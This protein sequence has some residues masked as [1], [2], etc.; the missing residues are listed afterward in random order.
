ME[1]SG[2]AKT[3]LERR[4]LCKDSQGNLVED[5]PGM[6]MRVA[7]AIAAADSEFDPKADIA[8]TAD[9]FLRLMTELKFMP[10]SPT[11]MNAG[12]HL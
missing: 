1:L 6:F 7:G 12:K 2:N 8:A 3:V 11:L 4:Y 5:I 10:N 9:E